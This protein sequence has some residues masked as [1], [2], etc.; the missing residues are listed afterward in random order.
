MGAGASRERSGTAA[1]YAQQVRAVREAVDAVVRVR[2]ALTLEALLAEPRAVCDILSC[3]AVDLLIAVDAELARADSVFTDAVLARFEERLPSLQAAPKPVLP[4]LVP[5]PTLM[6]GP[7]HWSDADSAAR[8]ITDYILRAL[9]REALPALQQLRIGVEQKTDFVSALLVLQTPTPAWRINVV[10][11]V[12]LCL[13]KVT[14]KAGPAYVTPDLARFFAEY[15]VPF[16]RQKGQHQPSAAQEVTLVLERCLG[17][18]REAERARSYAHRHTHTLEFSSRAGEKGWE[19][20]DRQHQRGAAAS[21]SLLE[22]PSPG[23]IRARVDEYYRQHRAA[24]STQRTDPLL[25]RL[26]REFDAE[27]GRR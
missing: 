8:R 7:P 4:T 27:K 25:T 10:P 17:P 6:K 11:G 14:L 15:V 22:P 9:K 20:R 1:E 16:L 26:Q 13:H 2:E 18:P 3:D 23:A 24:P 19:E 12:F 5:L 21:L